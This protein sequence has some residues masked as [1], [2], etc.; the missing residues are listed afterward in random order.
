[1]GKTK[2]KLKNGQVTLGA[3]LMIGHPTVG[4]LLAGE[5]FDWIAVD[6]EHTTIDIHTFYQLAL[7]IK[8]R[9]SDIFARLHS[10]DPVQAKLILDAGADGIIIPSVNSAAEARQAVAMA[11]YPPQGF[12][13]CSFS[14]ATDFGRNLNHYFSSHNDKVVVVVQFEHIKAL[15]NADAILSTPGI[16]A[17]FIGPYDLS[18]SLGKAGQFDDPQVRA[19]QEKIL[20]ACQR[21]GIPP[22]IHVVSQDGAKLRASINQGFRFIACGLDTLFILDSCRAMLK[23]VSENA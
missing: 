6:M 9:G 17:A 4:E 16:D 18:A 23:G 11:K 20:Q 21:H 8:P 3:W 7:A 1:M 14:R 13:G 15:E 2:E 19:A 10:C 22:G 12:R 5:G